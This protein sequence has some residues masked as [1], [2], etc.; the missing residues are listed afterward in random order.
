MKDLSKNLGVSQTLMSFWVNGLQSV[1]EEKTK[2]IAE[3]FAV[4]LKTL[5]EKN[6]RAGCAEYLTKK[7]KRIFGI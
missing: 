7:K 6:L 4:D 1:P 2:M 3:F 5:T